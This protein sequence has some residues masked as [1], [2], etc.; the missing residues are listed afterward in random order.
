MRAARFLPKNHPVVTK[1]L[2]DHLVIDATTMMRFALEN[3]PSSHPDI[4]RIE[5]IKKQISPHPYKWKFWAVTDTLHDSLIEQEETVIKLFDFNLWVM[6]S[7]KSPCEQPAILAIG[8][9]IATP[10]YEAFWKKGPD[11]D[12]LDPKPGMFILVAIDY[13][14][15]IPHEWREV[16][17]VKPDMLSGQPVQKVLL[18]SRR[19]DRLHTYF[20]YCQQQAFLEAAYPDQVRPGDH[21]DLVR[22]NHPD[23]NPDL[24]QEE[25]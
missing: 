2:D 10:V 1:L 20:P 7:E 17:H 9:D 11:S 21:Q 14:K 25:L 6:K 19:P 16:V 4:T 23:D 5:S 22:S 15:Q 12:P 8:A 3:C 18:A 13:K 24:R